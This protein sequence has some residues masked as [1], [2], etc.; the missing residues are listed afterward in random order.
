MKLIDDKDDGNNEGS[1]YKIW[2]KDVFIVVYIF[3]LTLFS[4]MLVPFQPADPHPPHRFS[5]MLNLTPSH[6]VH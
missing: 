2:Q 3:F 6:S 1:D 5:N 4:T